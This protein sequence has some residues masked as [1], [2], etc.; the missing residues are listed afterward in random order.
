VILEIQ[1]QQEQRVMQDRSVKQVLLVIPVP[2][3]KRERPDKPVQQDIPE[4]VVIQVIQ[5]TLVL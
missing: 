5:V 4:N 3:E 2:Q 1:D